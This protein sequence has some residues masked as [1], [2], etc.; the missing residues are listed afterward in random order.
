MVRIDVVDGLVSMHVDDRLS[1][2]RD[3]TVPLK[4]VNATGAAA[5][6]GRVQ[7]NPP[8]DALSE[9]RLDAMLEP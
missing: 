8:A 2:N 6:V 7:L 5:V 9:H 1:V 4:P 3:P